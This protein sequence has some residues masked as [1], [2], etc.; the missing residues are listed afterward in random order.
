MALIIRQFGNSTIRKFENAVII[1]FA[2][3]L[4]FKVNLSHSLKGLKQAMN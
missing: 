4:R 2:F 3:S 1:V